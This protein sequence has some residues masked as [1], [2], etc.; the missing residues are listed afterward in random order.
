V[1]ITVDSLVDDH[2]RT[3]SPCM[4]DG[5]RVQLDDVGRSVP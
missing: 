1:P 4:I 3:V 2:A 5:A